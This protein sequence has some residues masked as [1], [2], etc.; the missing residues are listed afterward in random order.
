MASPCPNESLD[1]VVVVCPGQ[2]L[3][4]EAEIHSHVLQALCVIVGI[5]L[6]YTMAASLLRVTA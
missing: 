1:F 2:T 5:L 4:A 6:G 3:V